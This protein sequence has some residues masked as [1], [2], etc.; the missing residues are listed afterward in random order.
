[1]KGR[2]AF[3]LA[4]AAGIAA[5]VQVDA[6]R[7]RSHRIKPV[8]ET[9]LVAEPVVRSVRVIPIWCTDSSA[10]FDE[11]WCNRIERAEV[12]GEYDRMRALF[13]PAAK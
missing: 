10:T 3:A 6:R 5:S 11:H 12:P 2:V 8:R 7:H 4:L 13:E 9:I 1:M